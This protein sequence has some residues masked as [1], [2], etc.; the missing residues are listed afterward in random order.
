LSLA[1]RSICNAES[2]FFSPVWSPPKVLLYCVNIN[3]NRPMFLKRK[4][5]PYLIKIGLIVYINIK[6]EFKIF[7]STSLIFLW[8]T[9][10]VY[11]TANKVFPCGSRTTIRHNTNKTSQ[12]ITH[13]S[14][15]KHNIQNYSHNKG[16]TIHNEYNTNT[17]TTTTI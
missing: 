10:I 14:Q 2:F 6:L 3:G 1:Q 15:T 5:R 12:K 4:I 8:N 11:L 7:L 9:I 13:H 17:I 16:H